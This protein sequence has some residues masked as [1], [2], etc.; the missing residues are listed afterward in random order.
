MRLVLPFLAIFFCFAVVK[1]FHRAPISPPKGKHEE[2][3]FQETK[4]DTDESI[5]TAGQV[6]ALCLPIIA[7]R[8]MKHNRSAIESEGV[9]FNFF[10]ESL[11][12]F[13][14]AP[15]EYNVVTHDAD[16]GKSRQEYDPR[17]DLYVRYKQ[18]KKFDK[19]AQY[20]IVAGNINPKSFMQKA[21]C[22]PEFNYISQDT[23]MEFSEYFK[24]RSISIE[25]ARSFIRDDNFYRNFTFLMMLNLEQ[26]NSD[27]EL[28]KRYRL[29][30]NNCN[31]AISILYNFCVVD[32]RY[33]LQYEDMFIFIN[34]NIV[35]S[36]VYCKRSRDKAWTLVKRHLLNVVQ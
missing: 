7:N 24:G 2:C 23:N 4:S 30:R 15:N 27:F 5:P 26:F 13:Y 16:F 18:V 31:K 14:E 36:N 3:I 1:A 32:P 11:K 20:G 35:A 17:D 12:E 33:D 22:T 10:K 9:I 29:F 6:K 19:K 21:R 25:H 28:F 34:Q 8:G